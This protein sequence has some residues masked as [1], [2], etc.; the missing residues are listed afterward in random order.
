MHKPLTHKQLAAA[1]KVSRPYI[2]KL[3]SLGMPVSSIPDAK[4]WLDQQRKAS[5]SGKHSPSNLNA[6]RVENLLLRNQLLRLEIAQASDVSELIS[7]DRLREAVDN[8]LTWARISGRNAAELNALN[9]AAAGTPQKAFAIATEM[10]EDA[11]FHG[12]I[13]MLAG[14]KG[15]DEDPRLCALVTAAIKSVRGYTDE[16]L[17]EAVEAFTRAVIASQ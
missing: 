1:L 15:H 14:S 17:N 9:L 10:V 5:S 2:T 8:Y 4:R 3:V 12:T 11:F 7:C 6:V 13:A 16:Q